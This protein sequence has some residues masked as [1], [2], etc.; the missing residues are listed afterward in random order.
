MHED[1]VGVHVRMVASVQTD[2]P[3]LGG[4]EA[5]RME[6]AAAFRVSCHYRY[7]LNIMMSFPKTKRFFLSA[8]L[9]SPFSQLSPYP[10]RLA[11]RP[12]TLHGRWAVAAIGVAA[13]EPD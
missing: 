10:V 1:S 13:V 12:R 2:T 3:G 7:F 8:V 6:L 9:L 11:R 5:L 4:E